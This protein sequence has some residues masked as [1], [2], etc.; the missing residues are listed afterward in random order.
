MTLPQKVELISPEEYLKG[1]KVS[2]VKHEYIKGQVYSMAGASDAHV[3]IA[4][5]LLSLL[6]PKIREK[7]C[8]VYFSDMKVFIETANCYFY[9][10]IFVACDARDRKNDYFKKYP[11]LIIEVLSE[12]TVVFDRGKNFPTTGSWKV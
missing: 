1:E 6:R 9:P 2:D 3:T 10:D 11:N 5:N 12:S 8:K 7:S 4:G